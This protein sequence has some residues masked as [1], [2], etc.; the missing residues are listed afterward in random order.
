MT[1]ATAPRLR[2]ALER[3][4]EALRAQFEA[5]APAGEIVAGRAAAVDDALRAAW[6]E[7]GVGD[8]DAALV[9]VGGYGRSELHPGSDVDLLVLVGAKR[10]AALRRRRADPR[11]ESYIALAWDLGIEVGHAVRSVRQCATE[12]RRDLTVITNMVEA[13]HLAGSRALFEKMRDAVSPA[14]M[15]RPGEFLRAK[16]DEQRKRHLRHRDSGYPLEPNVKEGPGGLR[17]V[18]TVAWIARRYFGA[19]EGI[20]PGLRDLF[21][22][23]FLTEDELRALRDGQE[24]LWQVRMALHYLAGRREDRLLFDRQSA[25]A[26]H[27]GYHD[28]DHHRGVERFMKRYN[29]TI[30]SVSR[31]NELLLQ[32]FRERF[33]ERQ[34]GG[35]GAV[36]G[37]Y[38][39]F[40]ARG[41]PMTCSASPAGSADRSP[42]TSRRRCAPTSCGCSV[43]GRRVRV[44]R[45]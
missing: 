30:Q 20:E 33:L 37:L 12:G 26:E 21:D 34:N 36:W 41:G 2:A 24:L 13:R 27:F 9:A 31:L 38:R 18:Q 23:G 17:D 32:V 19:R 10:A 11:I 16:E 5:G 14:R 28:A 15:W 45:R 1:S 35:A 7:V 42:P 25:V 6:N 43:R 40:Q 44:S 4:G 8:D 3:R 29:R 22:H 39:R